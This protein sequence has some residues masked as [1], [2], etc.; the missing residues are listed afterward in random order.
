MVPRLLRARR[1][2]P[3]QTEVPARSD[4]ARPGCAT[5]PHPTSPPDPLLCVGF[6]RVDPAVVW[7]LPASATESSFLLRATSALLFSALT[8]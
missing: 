7:A 3:L 2:V 4:E 6:Q 8:T 5:P 1:D